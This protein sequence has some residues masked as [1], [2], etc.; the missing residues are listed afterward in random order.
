ML[1]GMLASSVARGVLECRRRRRPGGRPSRTQVQIRPVV[2]ALR[3]DPDGVVS[4]PAGFH[5]Q[6]LAEPG[7]LNGMRAV[8][9]REQT[10][11][12]TVLTE[13]LQMATACAAGLATD[14]EI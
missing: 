7:V 3:Q 5:L 10:L 1:L 4:R 14:N 2:H 8:L 13:L 11:L 9:I 6:P 12:S